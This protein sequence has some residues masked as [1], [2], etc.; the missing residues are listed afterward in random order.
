MDNLFGIDHRHCDIEIGDIITVAGIRYKV[1]KK[2]TTAIAVIRW[3]W[4]NRL[5]AWLA[6]R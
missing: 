5:F 1:T 3:W 2:T 4:W 6:K